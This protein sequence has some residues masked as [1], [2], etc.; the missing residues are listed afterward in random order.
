LFHYPKDPFNKNGAICFTFRQDLI[1]TQPGQ[2]NRTI[3]EL[4]SFLHPDNGVSLSYNPKERWSFNGDKAVLK[5]A[6]RGQEFIFTADPNE[7]V[8]NWCINLIK[9]NSVTD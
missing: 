7:A 3:W 9:H 1:L 5:A 4:P 6:G 8:E 2:Q